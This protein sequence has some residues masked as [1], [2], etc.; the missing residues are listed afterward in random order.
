MKIIPPN[1]PNT[2][3]IDG[4]SLKVGGIASRLTL[5][6]SALTGGTFHVELSLD[7]VTFVRHSTISAAGVYDIQSA[8]NHI[9]AVT[10]TPTPTATLFISGYR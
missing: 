9:R 1:Y 6:V 3:A 2:L 8:C 4:P 7:G 5:Y 10:A